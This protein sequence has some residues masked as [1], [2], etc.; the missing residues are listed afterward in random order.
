MTLGAIFY[1]TI[2]P[3]TFYEIVN[4]NLLPLLKGGREGFSGHFQMAKLLPFF[5]CSNLPTFH[6]SILPIF[7]SHLPCPSSFPLQTPWFNIPPKTFL[8]AF[9][10]SNFSDSSQDV[11]LIKSLKRRIS[12]IPAKFS[13]T[14]STP[15]NP[16]LAGKIPPRPPL[17][18][19]VGGDLKVIF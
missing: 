18:K 6:H 14:G 17:V 1:E 12:A 8:Q 13:M 11:F 3:V 9:Q 10:D 5:H 19:G 16:A 4:F 2:V 15:A 7:Y